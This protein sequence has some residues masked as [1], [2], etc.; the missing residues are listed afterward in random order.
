MGAASEYDLYRV[1]RQDDWTAPLAMGAEKIPSGGRRPSSH[2]ELEGAILMGIL[3]RMLQKNPLERMTLPQL[4]VSIR[5]SFV[6][7][8][9]TLTEPPFLLFV[10]L[11]VFS[12]G[13]GPLES[14][15]ASEGHTQS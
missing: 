12:V 13:F 5:N 14:F 11:L 2:D 6:I 4:K 10:L 7:L 1:I 8:Q 3:D 9:S 15:M